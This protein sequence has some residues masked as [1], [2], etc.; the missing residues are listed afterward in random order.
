[1]SPLNC[2][3]QSASK[4]EGRTFG[5]RPSN[6]P[7]V[8]AHA[9]THQSCKEAEQINPTAPAVSAG[10][11]VPPFPGPACKL[12]HWSGC[13]LRRRMDPRSS[14]P[15]SGIRPHPT[16]REPNSIASV[17]H[18]DM[19]HQVKAGFA[20]VICWDET[21]D[22]SPANFNTS[23]VAVICSPNRT[24]MPH[25][26]GLVVPRALASSKGPLMKHGGSSARTD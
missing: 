11:N 16:A 22:H 13:R 6:G 9:A 7:G 25:C 21:R 3:G 24:P 12:D 18:K 10:S 23:L 15:S 8:D 17:Q 14:R 2:S 19:E 5:P 26:F 4:Q 20:K 1:M